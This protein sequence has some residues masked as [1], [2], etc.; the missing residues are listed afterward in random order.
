VPHAD[1]QEPQ[2]TRY[3]RAGKLQATQIAGKQ[4]TAFS[5]RFKGK[6]LAPGRYRALVTA[7]DALGARSAERRVSFRIVMP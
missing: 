2:C 5:G 4:S 1:P 7:A 6:A 3:T